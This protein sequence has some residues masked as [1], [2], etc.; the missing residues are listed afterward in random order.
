MS[1]ATPPNSHIKVI[2]HGAKVLHCRCLGSLEMFLIQ[3][4]IV[5][6]E[7]MV[8]EVC[9]VAFAWVYGLGLVA[10][11]ICSRDWQNPAEKRYHF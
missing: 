1:F 11:S 2:C 9:I 4:M 6:L 5:F 3:H 10:L 7:W 8:C